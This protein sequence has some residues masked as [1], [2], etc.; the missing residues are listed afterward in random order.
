[1]CGSATASPCQRV[2]A[3]QNSRPPTTTSQGAQGCRRGSRALSRSLARAM[4]SRDT[5]AL[6]P[7]F[8]ELE[9]VLENASI[10]SGRARWWKIARAFHVSRKIHPRARRAIQSVRTR[11]TARY[12]AQDQNGCL[13]ALPQYV[14]LARDVEEIRSKMGTYPY[15]TVAIPMRKGGSFPWASSMAWICIKTFWEP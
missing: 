8:V 13:R 10:R 12:R 15:L 14:T 6:I 11:G 5:V 4:S 2:Y 3:K 1:M 9:V 7:A